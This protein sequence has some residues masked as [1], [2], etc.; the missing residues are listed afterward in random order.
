MGAT[1]DP[2]SEHFGGL[3]MPQQRF[4]TRRAIGNLSPANAKNPSCSREWKVLGDA[5]LSLSFFLR[6]MQWTDIP[7]RQ[8]TLSSS[9]PLGLSFHIVLPLAIASFPAEHSSAIC[10]TAFFDSRRT[11]GM[12]QYRLPSK[13]ESI[14]AESDSKATRYISFCSTPRLG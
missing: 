11:I 9:D 7:C 6:I 13:N 3:R 14:D 1:K 4:Q 8:R 5:A 2:H 12:T 10:H